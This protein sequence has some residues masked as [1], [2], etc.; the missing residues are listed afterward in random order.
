VIKTKKMKKIILLFLL[1]ST[2]VFSQG[3]ILSSPEEKASFP[4]LPSDKL[5]F[6]EVLPSSYSLEKYVPPVRKQK[7]G[8]CVGF[9]SFYYALSTMYNISFDITDPN[10]KY[11]HSFDPYFLYSIHFNDQNDCEGGLPFETAF[12]NLG[13]IGAKKLFY[14]PFTNCET[15]WTTTKLKNTLGYTTPYSIENWYY[16]DKNNVSDNGLIEIVKKSLYNDIPVITGFKFVKSMYSYNSENVL[17]VKSNGLW[18]PKTYESKEGGHALCVVGY[19]DYK[20]GGAFRIVNSWG[21]NY[22]DNGYLWVKYEDFT[23]FVELAFILDLNK[24]I[25]RLPPTEIVTNNYKRFYYKNNS[26]SYNSYEGQYLGNGV[27]GYGIFTDKEYDT[28]YVGN[29]EDGDMTGFFLVVDKDGVFSAS[30]V[31]GKLQDFEKL[32]FA[33]QDNELM[34]TQLEA[35]RYFQ[36]LG[37]NLSIRKSNSS[38]PS[39]IKQKK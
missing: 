26:N 1:V 31:D 10:E 32:G 36:K 11:A 9:A 17:G 22:G 2:Q 15:N 13:K 25:K 6:V 27:N 4:K 16:I 14:P 8:T 29:F 7:G 20:F 33:S 18:D 28:H 37:D 19:S 23:E 21:T 3:L 30:A 35:K 38:R 5:G 34:K 39:I 12:N 24:N